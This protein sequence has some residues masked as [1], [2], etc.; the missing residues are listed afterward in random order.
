[1]AL[2]FMEQPNK[3]VILLLSSSLFLWKKKTSNGVVFRFPWSCRALCIYWNNNFFSKK[4][5]CVSQKLKNEYKV[6]KTS[7]NSEKNIVF[8]ICFASESHSSFVS[9]KTWI[10]RR[11]QTHVF[12][13]FSTY[14][15]TESKSESQHVCAH[16]C[17]RLT[18]FY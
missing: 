9:N 3:H 1:M 15:A 4:N 16:L 6:R 13:S 18:I 10:K 11:Q 5:S 14:S 8:A 2:L 17:I 12:V 7:V